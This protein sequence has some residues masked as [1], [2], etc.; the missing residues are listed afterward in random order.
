MELGL[1]LT[2]TLRETTYRQYLLWQLWLAKQ[3]NS[4]DRH[5]F[6]LMKVCQTIERMHARSN[7][8]LDL[9]R[10]K[11]QFKDPTQ[12]TI[13]PTSIKQSKNRWI[14]NVG[15]NVVRKVINVDN[16]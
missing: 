8:K 15:G 4:P 5:D 1:P 7:K 2:T 6:Y 3:W 14:S 11:V 12:S 16:N 9:G 10:Y 13:T